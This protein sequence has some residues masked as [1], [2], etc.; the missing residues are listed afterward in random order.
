M[1]NLIEPAQI[2][3]AAALA[4]LVNS[5]YRGDSSR[6]GWTTEANLLDG[7]R[8]DEAALLEILRKPG[9]QILK[10][11]EQAKLL[12]CVYLYPDDH[13]LY[14]GML[15][16]QPLRQN[17]GLG[18]KLMAAAERE[19]KKL[20]CRSVYMLVI[21]ERKELIEWYIRHGYQDKGER[22]PFHI[23]DVRFGLPR[24]PLEFLVLEKSL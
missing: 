6:L 10:Y 21:S 17:S 13:R 22:R 18:K 4:D 7:G 15:S 12:G 8:T 2:T 23:N 3:D 14:L 1:A 11:T 5:A 16:V 9:H 19:G 20:G 24:K